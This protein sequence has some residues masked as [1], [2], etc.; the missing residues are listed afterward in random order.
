MNWND[1]PNFPDVSYAFDESWEHLESWLEARKDI[2]IILD[3]EYQRGYVWTREQKI[4]YL[5]YRL[6]GGIS[7][8]DLF[9][10]SPGW[11]GRGKTQP[12]SI[13]DGKQR[14]LTVREF[15][16]GELPVFGRTFNE[17]EG[18]F[19]WSDRR[20]SF[21]IHINNLLDEQDVIR[22]YL[23]MNTGGS[24]HTREELDRV[25]ELLVKP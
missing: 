14:L 20:V 6:Q 9:W 19:P 12:I 13:V 24:I 22:W 1:I 7:G 25:E 8:G 23:S 18:I 2:G 11:R 17:F 21:R 16:R 4:A 15:M 10:N 5:E 3:P